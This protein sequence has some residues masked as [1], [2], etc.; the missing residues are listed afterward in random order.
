[1]DMPGRSTDK[2]CDVA[3]AFYCPPH[4]ETTGV[5]YTH[6]CVRMLKTHAFM[7]SEG[8]SIYIK[9]GGCEEKKK[10]KSACGVSRESVLKSVDKT[11]NFRPALPHKVC[12][13]SQSGRRYQPRMV[14]LLLHGTGVNYLCIVNY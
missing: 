10:S 11:L 6:T 7:M 9:L 1:M 14:A 3:S 8:Q 4:W 13:E 5:V 2:Y 12:T